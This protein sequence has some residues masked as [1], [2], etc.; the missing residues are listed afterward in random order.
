MTQQLSESLDE[1][2]AVLLALYDDAQTERPDRFLAQAIDRAA[3]WLG[4]EPTR[5]K[6]KRTCVAH[7]PHNRPQASCSSLASSIRHLKAVREPNNAEW[8]STNGD[9]HLTTRTEDHDSLDELR[10]YAEQAEFSLMVSGPAG[11]RGLNDAAIDGLRCWMPHVVQALRLNQNHY[12]KRLQQAEETVALVD[13]NGLVWARVGSP[14]ALSDGSD[15]QSHRLT[16]TVTTSLA[17]QGEWRGARV[18]YSAKPLGPF[19]VLQ[20]TPVNALEQLT[21][22]EQDIAHLFTQGYSYK[23]VA[24]RLSIS[25]ATVRNHIARIYS[26]TEVR[27]KVALSLLLAG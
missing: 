14:D 22:R 25:P 4:V 26:K 13:R 18:Q 12:L 17:K 3:H 24:L 10:C 1:L 8:L 11:P 9:G 27:N 2:N 5:L 19:F 21:P 7:P 16:G 6:L 20:S 15:H 23:E